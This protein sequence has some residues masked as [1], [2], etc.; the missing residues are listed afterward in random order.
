MASTQ[1]S[2]RLLRNATIY[3]NKD[4][5]FNALSAMTGV[6]DG[7]PVLAR[8][9][10]AGK[11]KTLLGLYSKIAD[12][13]KHMTIFDFDSDARKALEQK[14]ETMSGDVTTAITAAIEAL[15]V[16]TIT[17]GEGEFIKSVGES[18]GK[19]TATTGEMP[20]V[21]AITEAGKPIVAVAQNK[22]T[23]SASA[24]TINA[25]H[26]NVTGSVFSSTTVQGALEEIETEYKAADD[27]LKKEIL[28]NASDTAN[29]LAKLEN[30]INGA[31]SDA[32]SYTISALT[33]EEINVLSDGANVREA[34]KLVDEDNIQSG[35][36]IKIYK[37][38]TLKSAEYSGQNLILTYVQ[39][40][41]TETAVTIDMHDLIE[42]TE[43][44][45]G[46]TWDATASKVRGVV[47]PTSENFLTVGADG[48]K[49]A[50]VQSAIDNAVSGA[51]QTLDVTGDTAVSGQYVAAIEETDG[52]VAV[53]TRAN[54]SEAPLNGYTKGSDSGDVVATD[55]INAAISKLEKQIDAVEV[56]AQASKTIVEEGTDAGD[57][58][59]ISSRTDA[60]TS[61]VTYT[62]SLA[63]VASENALTA[64]TAARKAVD[65]VNGDAYTADTN[66]HY[67][68]DANSLYAADQALDTALS[69]VSDKVDALSGKSITGIEMTG[70]T[71][72]IT[73]NTD[74]TKKI[75]INTDASQLN[76]VNKISGATPI[77]AGTSVE[78]ALQT[79][80]DNV[81]A[82]KVVGS[83]AITTGASSD[84][85][86]QVSLK[87]DEA[88][89]AG[90]T[91]A[92]NQQADNHNALK[93]TSDGLFLSDVWD[94]GTY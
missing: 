75:T 88:H 47:D 91:E 22:G 34:Y 37:D 48:F 13:T 1:K 65:G 61:S 83:Y 69:S 20:T 72:A 87:L 14:I 50:G 58:M 12:G 59:S 94:A 3:P 55:S 26:V 68:S 81:S 33:Q 60:S 9:T 92:E 10:E 4:A 21:A 8:Y 54:V 77:A 57:H 7:V 36:T 89:T 62:I 40:D 44:A 84:S 38:Q 51:V 80:Y 27:A 35:A 76:T 63:D 23:V 85:N 90:T 45:S 93:I 18:D 28:G 25:E 56:Q 6:E 2:L 86:T 64:E 70:G 46:V 79:I 41:G 82:N 24:G 31:V 32:K 73:A 66:A 43:F 49:V 29:T 30:I 74:G 16:D 42:Q 15:D 39:A 17:A 52:I 67:I 71:A 53:K 78:N 19:I 11:E 5:A